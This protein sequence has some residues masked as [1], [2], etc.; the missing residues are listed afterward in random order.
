[1]D[2]LVSASGFEI[3]LQRLRRTAGAK[4][5]F[6][7]QGSFDEPVIT[8]LITWPSKR[9]ADVKG[10]LESVGDGVLVTGRVEVEIDMQCSRCLTGFTNQADVGFQELFIYPERAQQ[11]A[12]E[13]VY[14]INN[15][16]IDL[17]QALHDVVIL[18]QPLI[19]LCQPECQGLCPLCG[20][21]LNT[22]PEHT[23]L[24]PIDSPWLQLA[25]WGKMSGADS[26]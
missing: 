21:D 8:G 17:A 10:L 15:E 12:D 3:S 5:E 18:D 20:V 11:Y 19:M 6:V 14:L 16:T 13:D 23:H 2:R 7:L 1:M 26:A 4:Q 22:E 25:K 24:A 9:M